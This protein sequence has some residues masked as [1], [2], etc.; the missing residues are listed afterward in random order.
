MFNRI[1]RVVFKEP[2]SSS[3]TDSETDTNLC[4]IAA[5]AP[6]VDGK[7]QIHPDTNHPTRAWEKLKAKQTAENV[8]HLSHNTPISSKKVRFVCIS[9]THNKTKGWNLT[10]IIPDGDILIHAGDFSMVGHPS[11]IEEFNNFLGMFSYSG[12]YACLK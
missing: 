4:D 10:E 1:K 11:Q 12:I 6:F 2:E 3:D 5:F 7:V 8:K 9:D